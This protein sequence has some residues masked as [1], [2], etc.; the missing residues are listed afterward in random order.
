MD[1]NNFARVTSELKKNAPLYRLDLGITLE[2]DLVFARSDFLMLFGGINE[3]LG[4]IIMQYM[5]KYSFKMK[6][7]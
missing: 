4:L 7:T 5:F 3:S 2:K 1:Q 6:I